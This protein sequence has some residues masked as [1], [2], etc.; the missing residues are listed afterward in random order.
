MDIRIG[1]TSSVVSTG[2]VLMLGLNT[3]NWKS[4][5]NTPLDTAAGLLRTDIIDLLLRYDADVEK[6]AALHKAVRSRS[7]G[8]EK[9]KE[10]VDFLLGKDKDLVNA[11]ESH[12]KEH[13]LK[14]KYPNLPFGTAFH[15]AVFRGG[16]KML[17][18]LLRVG[19]N[20]EIRMKKFNGEET[21]KALDE[22]R[23]QE[24]PNPRIIELLGGS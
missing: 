21:G 2:F 23:A 6:S 8:F 3:K 9:R 1:T 15:Q 12:E 24:E 4:K 22:T 7:G 18:H 20:K 17:D 10:V 13:F 19:A 5:S 16:D 14:E 11:L